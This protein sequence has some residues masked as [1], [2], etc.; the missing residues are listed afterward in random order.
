MGTVADVSCLVS[1]LLFSYYSPVEES[2]FETGQSAIAWI[3][4]LISTTKD[5]SERN[6]IVEYDGV[7]R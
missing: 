5:M 2:E 7:T 4:Y 3:T 1:D 6:C